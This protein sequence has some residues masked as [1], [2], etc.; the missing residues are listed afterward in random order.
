MN[1]GSCVFRSTL[2]TSEKDDDFD[3]HLDEL[4]SFIG[5][6]VAQDMLGEEYTSK[7]ILEQGMGTINLSKY[8]E[9]Q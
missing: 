1:M 7:A 8:N 3:L 6:Q 5:L 2:S 4:E 9:L